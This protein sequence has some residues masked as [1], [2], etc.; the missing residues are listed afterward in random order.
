M[1]RAIRFI[2]GGAVLAAG[3]LVFSPLAAALFNT[4]LRADSIESVFQG[5]S[6]ALA[7]SAGSALVSA[8]VSLLL[9]LPFALAAEHAS[10]T[11]R[12]IC[13]SL[14]LFVLIVPPYI[15]GEAWIVLL[16]PAGKL[17]R[18]IATWLGIGPQSS[19][20]VAIARF[21]VPGFI[22]T[23]PSFGVLMGGCLFPI[24]ALAVLGALRRT[25]RRMLE[26]ARLARGRWGVFIVA[27]HAL[28]PPALGASL[29]VFAVTLTEFAVPQVLR[30]RTIGEA[31]YEQIQEGDLAA[32]TT[33][34]LPL[35][36]IVIAA[37]ALG[38]FVL[39]RSR[40]ASLA[41]LEGEVPRY[42]P[43][44]TGL[45][46]DILGIV[47][48]LA[49]LTI[50]LILPILSLVWLGVTAKLPPS[51]VASAHKVLLAS[52]FVES[53]RGAWELAHDDAIRSVIMSSLTATVALTFAVVVVRLSTFL[54][55]RWILGALGAG[56]AVPAPI[57]GLG[58]IVLWNR[59]ATSAIYESSIVVVL[60]WLARFF[61]LVIFL[62]Q[63]AL[64]RVPRELEHAAA[65]MGRGIA[66]R[67][68]SVVIPSAAP[69]L[70]AAWLAM[71]VLCATEYCATLLV[72]PPGTALLAPSIVNLV[73]RGQDPEIAACEVLLLMVVALPIL[74]VA[75]AFVL[76]SR[77]QTPEVPS[78]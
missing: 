13:W 69:G 58:I 6:G 29:L 57:V 47:V 30:V 17:S 66:G 35:L 61:P 19:D 37:G 64:A 67:W 38:A 39:L 26:S 28:V 22:Y 1:K 7:N 3:A 40:S 55:W 78:P 4:H 62:S 21:A 2:A 23:W 15:A 53:F 63:A 49:S 32:A 76:R 46:R 73:R 75:V 60:A 71:Y 31:V 77:F 33:L 52:G 12:R 41:S 72:S 50:G 36:P 18:P 70:I 56:L 54:R 74:P 16:G 9:G 65:L 68:R 8:L 48:T 43:K 59:A 45:R 24:V 34:S 5:I 20:P 42:T 11:L 27:A 14:A 10:A 25:D 44:I 51:T